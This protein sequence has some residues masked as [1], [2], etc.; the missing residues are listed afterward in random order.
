MLDEIATL[1]ANARREGTK[2][3]LSAINKFWKCPAEERVARAK[4]EQLVEYPVLNV[5]GNITPEQVENY[6]QGLDMTGGTI[7]RIMPFFISPK[8]ETIRHPHAVIDNYDRVIK[9]LQKIAD[10]REQRTLI[11][12][13]EADD[14]RFE[15]FDTERKEP[16][17]SLIHI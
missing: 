4:G 1:F 6:L 15:W 2:N 12:S 11:F 3:L 10:S 9:S 8:T 16:N 17:L 5:W 13:P 7:N 14:A